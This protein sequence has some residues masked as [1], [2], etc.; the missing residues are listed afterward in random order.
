M[1]KIGVANMIAGLNRKNS[2][3]SHVTPAQGSTDTVKNPLYCPTPSPAKGNLRKSRFGSVKENIHKPRKSIVKPGSPI[4]Q[5]SKAIAGSPIRQPRSPL[6]P[7]DTNSPKRGPASGKTPPSSPL[8]TRLH[9]VAKR[10]SRR[11]QRPPSFNLGSSSKEQKEGSGENGTPAQQEDA[12]TMTNIE[13]IAVNGM[14]MRMLPVPAQVPRPA[15]R[16]ATPRNAAPPAPRE[17]APMPPRSGALPPPRVTGAPPVPEGVRARPRPAKQISGGSLRRG[18]PVPPPRK[19]LSVASDIQQ[20]ITPS[21]PASNTRSKAAS[22]E[23]ELTELLSKIRKRGAVQADYSVYQLVNLFTGTMPCSRSKRILS[24]LVEVCPA[25]QLVRWMIQSISGKGKDEDDKHKAADTLTSLLMMTTETSAQE[26]AITALKSALE[27]RQNL[28]VLVDCMAH[29]DWVLKSY[30]SGILAT[31]NVSPMGYLST[32]QASVGTTGASSESSSTESVTNALGV[33]NQLYRSNSAEHNVSASSAASSRSDVVINAAARLSSYSYDS[34][35][36]IVELLHSKSQEV[37]EVAVTTLLCMGP[38]AGG[39]VQ[40]LADLLAQ[41]KAP[42]VRGLCVSALKEIGMPFILK[43]I[44]VLEDVAKKDKDDGVR[45]AAASLLESV[46]LLSEEA[47]IE[48]READSM[49]ATTAKKMLISENFVRG[50]LKSLSRTA[51]GFTQKE[52]EKFVEAEHVMITKDCPRWRSQLRV[53][54]RRMADKGALSK[55]PATYRLV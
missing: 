48:S 46:D 45:R 38:V 47:R 32:N 6:T 15:A 3:A 54:I 20:P 49:A 35:P 33:T 25:D 18:L 5:P 41:E 7:T 36:H 44:D 11:F 13:R 37:R 12:S 42:K 43:V 23:E 50:V 52:I 39:A 26:E 10:Q 8:T 31:L 9:K 22:A 27:Q 30:V 29:N 55:Q 53:V 2:T 24:C 51:M 14:P 34:I 17:Q 19:A 1:N 40:Q 28:S 21:G 4:R 16:G